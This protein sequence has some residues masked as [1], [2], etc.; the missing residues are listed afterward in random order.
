MA[1]TKN[2]FD[3]IL[4]NQNK[5]MTT[6]SEYMNEAVELSA[7]NNEATEKAGELLNEF[8]TRPYQLAENLTAKE[9][10]EK[11]Q[12][13]FWTNFTTNYSK[14]MELSME[15]YQKTTDFWKEVWTKDNLMVQPDRAKKFSE[16]FQKSV[17]AYIDT[18]NANTKAI[19]DFFANGMIDKK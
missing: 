19:Q 7:P 16:I 14:S 1:G 8:F 15:L 12:E 17:K 13:D 5:L 11:Y 6:L 9:N 2:Y 10:L 3:Q 4:E 18:T